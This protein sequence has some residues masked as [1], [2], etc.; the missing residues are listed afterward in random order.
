MIIKLIVCVFVK[1]EDKWFL[2]S[3]YERLMRAAQT[4]R[5]QVPDPPIRKRFQAMQRKTFLTVRLLCLFFIV[6]NYVKVW[7]TVEAVKRRCLGRSGDGFFFQGGL[8]FKRAAGGHGTVRDCHFN[9]CLQNPR[10]SQNE[11]TV[12]HIS[13]SWTDTNLL[14]KKL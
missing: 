14:L 9:T 13:K 11:L 1:Q 2:Q 4:Q 3:S 12:E 8:Y 7:A 10:H 6:F 5:S